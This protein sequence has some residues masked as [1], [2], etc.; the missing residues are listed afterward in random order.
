MKKPSKQAPVGPAGTKN[1]TTTVP[2][3][4]TGMAP[5]PTKKK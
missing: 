2:A 4:K 1:T 3:G 5:S